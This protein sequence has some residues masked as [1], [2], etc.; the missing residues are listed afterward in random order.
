VLLTAEP[1]LQPLSLVSNSDSSTQLTSLVWE[2]GVEGGGCVRNSLSCRLDGL[3]EYLPWR[4][5][6]ETAAQ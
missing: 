5:H 2:Q 4:G 1:S 6:P 3:S